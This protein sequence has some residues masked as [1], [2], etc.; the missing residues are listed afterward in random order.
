MAELG[1]EGFARK[2]TTTELG[3]EAETGVRGREEGYHRPRQRS[4]KRAFWERL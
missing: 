2:D 3:L 1:G 4:C